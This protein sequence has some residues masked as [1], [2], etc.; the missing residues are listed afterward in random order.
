MKDFSMKKYQFLIAILILFIAIG[1]FYACNPVDNANNEK[2]TVVDQHEQ[3]A[4]D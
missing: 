1:S 4:T 3:R 2:Q